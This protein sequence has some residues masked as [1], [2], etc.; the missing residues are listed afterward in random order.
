MRDK[1]EDAIEQARTVLRTDS[2]KLSCVYS[3]TYCPYFVG[4]ETDSAASSN[5]FLGRALEKLNWNE[6]SEEAY[7]TAIG[8]KSK[9]ALAWQGL[10]GLYEK[11]SGKKLD[12]YHDAAIRLAELHM[13]E[14]V[15][16]RLLYIG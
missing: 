10:V 15:G 8:I 4:G 5:V 11:Q 7:R 9:D 12:N 13:N 1:Y 6:E 14:Y 16:Q 3:R 2:K